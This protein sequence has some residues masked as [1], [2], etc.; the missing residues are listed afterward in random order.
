MRAFVSYTA[1]TAVVY[2]VFCVYV[3]TSVLKNIYAFVC[4]RGKPVSQHRS[5]KPGSINR[6]STAVW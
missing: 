1:A 3:C 4:L 2:T 6:F 5:H